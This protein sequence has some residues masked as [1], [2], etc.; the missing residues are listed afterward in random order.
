MYTNWVYI[1]LPFRLNLRSG[2]G[3]EP[4]KDLSAEMNS[5]DDLSDNVFCLRV[6]VVC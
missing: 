2:D 1:I 6:L 5:D 3:D 4:D